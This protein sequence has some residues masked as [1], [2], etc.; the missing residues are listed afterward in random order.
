MAQQVAQKLL[1]ATASESG[2]ASGLGAW[3]RYVS[4]ML[5]AG[6]PWPGSLSCGPIVNGAVQDILPAGALYPTDVIWY[7]NASKTIQL[8]HLTY[9]RDGS[10]KPT[11]LVWQIFD[12]GGALALTVTDDITYSGLYEVE[13]VRTVS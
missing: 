6:L 4:Q 12:T 1:N 11:K 8:L 9:T 3:R 13:R 2:L 10:G 7:L 5:D